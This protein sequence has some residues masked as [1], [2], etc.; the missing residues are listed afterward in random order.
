MDWSSLVTQQSAWLKTHY[1]V[2]FLAGLFTHD[3]GMYPRRLLLAACVLMLA[4][5]IGFA[6]SHDLAVLVAVAV[7]GTLALAYPRGV[8]TQQIRD[9][10]NQ[11]T[12][13]HQ[14]GEL[15]FVNGKQFKTYRGMGSLGAMQSRGQGVARRSRYDSNM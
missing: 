5:G 10:V 7:V 13:R 3:P 4:T 14:P 9:A 15:V 8:M 11:L 1:P 12:T 6:A 2:E